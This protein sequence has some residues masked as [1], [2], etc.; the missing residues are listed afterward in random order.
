LL[1][2]ALR[3]SG[4]KGAPRHLNDGGGCFSPG[5][6]FDAASKPIVTNTGG[7]NVECNRGIV[8]S[9]PPYTSSHDESAE[10]DCVPLELALSLDGMK[11]FVS[12]YS[13]AGEGA[14]NVLV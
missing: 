12:N 3:Y 5:L 1:Q 14:F 4:G 6:A 10:G 8:I 7:G 9:A 13:N 11:L 2:R